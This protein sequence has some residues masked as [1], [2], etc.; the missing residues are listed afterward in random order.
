MTYRNDPD[1]EGL[2]S[3]M[4]EEPGTDPLICDDHIRRI[5]R[6]EIRAIIGEKIEALLKSAISIGAKSALGAL[7][8]NT[9]PT[10]THTRPVN[11]VAG[12]TGSSL[13]ETIAGM[14]VQSMAAKAKTNG[15]APEQ[16]TTQQP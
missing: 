4:H 13:A 6:E 2:L 5:V 15:S 3:Q 11:D 12:K 14:M 16:T 7:T 10:K 9:T 8:N 1:I